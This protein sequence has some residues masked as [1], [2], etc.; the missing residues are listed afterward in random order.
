MHSPGTST[1]VRLWSLVE[2]APWVRCYAGRLPSWARPNGISAQPQEAHHSSRRPTAREARIRF[3][4]V[5]P[6]TAIVVIFA[7]QII[8]Y[9]PFKVDDAYIAF[10]YSKNLVNGNGLTYNGLVVE[11]FS[12]FLWTILMVPVLLC[13]GD[14]LN[15]ARVLSLLS[16]LATLYLTGRLVRRLEPR[17]S[18]STV[19][20]TVLLLA[21]SV[22]FVAWTVG[23]L[24]TVWMTFLVTLLVYVESG[25]DQRTPVFSALVVLACALSRPEG[26]MLFPVLLVYRLIARTSSVK[27][28][29]WW[30]LL[31]LLPYFAFLLW[32]FLTF[33]YL[34]PNTAY[35]KVK[36]G[37]ETV[38]AAARW[39]V[40]FV[41][42]RPTLGVLMV[43][44]LAFL[45]REHHTLMRGWYLVAATI[46]AYVF[47]VLFS[48]PDW[49]P[50]YRLIVPILPLLSVLAGSAV[51][52]T[53]VKQHRSLRVLAVALIV[54]TVLLELILSATVFMPPTLD[55]GKDVDVLIKAG[56][57][58]RRNTA[59]GDTIAV[60]DAGALAYYGERSTV[61]ILGLNDEHI[62]HSP[63]KS[64]PYYVLAH[65]PLLVQL[66]VTMPDNGSEPTPV[67][68]LAGSHLFYTPEFQR[69]YRPIVV[70]IDE[71][72]ALV[73]YVRR[74]SP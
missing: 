58:I 11:G 43:F 24:E 29:V 8:A 53:S 42:L 2:T 10:V 60:V 54:A 36:P 48:G 21:T 22:C 66:Q 9:L 47:Y 16:A 71:S 23:G 3:V 26:V 25:P 41:Q 62:A 44:S 69:S 46:G 27:K 28:T 74:P 50:H 19:F 70:P 40:S 65:Q 7:L 31:F 61:D 15:A 34:L 57:W 64:D 20:L 73:F 35:A 33:G 51:N 39:L 55:L 5:I 38:V 32:R 12:S 56:K 18:Q 17:S 52:A 72:K 4:K 14:P 68:S 59:P 30:S 13:N 67:D 45:T 49:M 1:L 63:N 37:S 6:A